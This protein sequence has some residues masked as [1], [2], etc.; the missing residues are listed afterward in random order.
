MLRCWEQH[1]RSV[2]LVDCSKGQLQSVKKETIW[3]HKVPTSIPFLPRQKTIAP[4]ETAHRNFFPVGTEP[5]RHEF[6]QEQYSLGL[7]RGVTRGFAVSESDHHTHATGFGSATR[8]C[9]TKMG[10]TAQ[11]TRLMGGT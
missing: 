1:L 3:L 7:G 8:T 2:A 6:S 11:G 4:G 9:P 10:W 5:T